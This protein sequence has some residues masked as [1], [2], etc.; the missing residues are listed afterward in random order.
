[1]SLCKANE[2][3]QLLEGL[4]GFC[5][6]INFKY[7]FCA[8][9]RW[10]KK[11]MNIKPKLWTFWQSQMERRSS[12]RKNIEMVLYINV[13]SH[14][15][16]KSRTEEMLIYYVVHNNSFGVIHSHFIRH[17]NRAIVCNGY[18]RW[19]YTS[20][21]SV[22]TYKTHAKNEK[23]FF[24]MATWLLYGFDSPNIPFSN[25]SLTKSRAPGFIVVRVEWK[26]KWNVNPAF[27]S[28]KINFNAKIG[29]WAH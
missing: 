7:G 1:M 2:V 8:M 20:S 3:K 11:D 24:P 21:R 15:R 27:C 23:N 10:Q 9:F 13:F 4:H 29:H 22:P 16:R 6:N 26:F 19:F 18:G 28:Q 5:G 17:N 12:G 25:K 14:L